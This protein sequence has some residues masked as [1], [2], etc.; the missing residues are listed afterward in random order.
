V[1]FNITRVPFLPFY[2][3]YIVFALLDNNVFP[4]R[5]IVPLSRTCTGMRHGEPSCAGK[6]HSGHLRTRS[7][8]FPRSCILPHAVLRERDRDI[9]RSRQYLGLFCSS[10]TSY[11]SRFN[12][13]L[14]FKSTIRDKSNSLFQVPAI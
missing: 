12:P 14:N 8:A 4:P 1:C 9:S 6:S 13:A 3:F 7:S 10:A 11:P 2:L 5:K